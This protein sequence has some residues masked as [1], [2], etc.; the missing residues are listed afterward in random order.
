MS[1]IAALFLACVYSSCRS[2]THLAPRI[3]VTPRSRHRL[4][5]HPLLKSAS[6]FLSTL[7]VKISSRLASICVLAAL[8]PLLTF[9]PFSG[10]INPHL[11]HEAVRPKA[12]GFPWN[13]VWVRGLQQRTRKTEESPAGE[14]HPSRKATRLARVG[15][16]V[17]TVPIQATSTSARETTTQYSGDSGH[18]Q[19]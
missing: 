17:N 6:F 1:H 2:K 9:S 11:P 15:K 12:L 13:W 19:R 7:V 3:R 18:N 14:W 16:I 10:K 4:H 8:T 5:T